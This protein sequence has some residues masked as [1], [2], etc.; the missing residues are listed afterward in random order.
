MEK[1]IFSVISASTGPNHMNKEK[2][3]LNM[4]LFS[5][6]GASNLNYISQLNAKELG[7]NYILVIRIVNDPQIYKVNCYLTSP[8]G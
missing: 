3:L 2:H 7:L 5:P 6:L 4:S 1:Y 8:P